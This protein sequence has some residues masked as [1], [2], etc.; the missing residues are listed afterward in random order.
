MYPFKDVTG[1]NLHLYQALL[2]L[3]SGG[4]FGLGLGNSRQKTG[5]LPFPYTDSI[6]PIIGEEVGFVGC[7]VIVLLFLVLAFR[8][9]R[10]ARRSPD[11]YGALLATGITTWLILQAIINIGANTGTIPFTGVPLPFFSF[12]GS[13]LVVSMAAVGVLLNF[14]RYIEGPESRALGLR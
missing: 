7:A 12:G 3:G 9:F 1:I 5:Y 10:L 6:F 11:L 2:A 8:G 14:S 4:W 13:S